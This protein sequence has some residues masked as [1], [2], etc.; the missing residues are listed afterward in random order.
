MVKINAMFVA[1]YF[2]N[3]TMQKKT[4]SVTIYT[5]CQQPIL[6][7][8]AISTNFVW[9]RQSYKINQAG[10]WKHGM[11]SKSAVTSTVALRN[12]VGKFYSFRKE[13]VRL[14]VLREGERSCPCRISLC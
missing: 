4:F 9:L 5:K 11:E 10:G 1:F 13:S 6:M 12:L 8:L 3:F 2:L 14:G 7:H